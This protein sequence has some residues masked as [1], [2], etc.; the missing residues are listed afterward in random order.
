VTVN[1]VGVTLIAGADIDSPGSPLRPGCPGIPA[2]P[3]QIKIKEIYG[4]CAYDRR[5][6]IL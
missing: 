2:A 1:V 6:R 4:T 3:Y 5:S